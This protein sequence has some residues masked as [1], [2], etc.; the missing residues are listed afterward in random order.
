M[1][2]LTLALAAIPPGE[3]HNYGLYIEARYKGRAVVL[4]R[5]SGEQ[6]DVGRA[7]DMAT[8]TGLL[9]GLL[10]ELRAARA[11]E[12]RAATTDR[13]NSSGRRKTMKPT[14]TPEERD[15]LVTRKRLEDYLRAGDPIQQRDMLVEMWRKYH[16]DAAREISGALKPLMQVQ[17]RQPGDHP[18]LPDEG[19]TND[20]YYV[21]LRRKEDLVF[22]SGPMIQLGIANHD[23]SARHDWRDFQAIK[24]QLAGP[25]CEAFELYPAERRLL[26]PSNYFTLWCFP[27]LGRIKVGQ[28]DRDVRNADV[29]LAPQRAFPKE[30][31]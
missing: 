15:H 28:D 27:K 6:C 31:K 24:N 22:R 21:T 2:P 16:P 9:D 10:A 1:T 13:R 30:E 18:E 12:A 20:T 17:T 4:R 5:C 25:D 8:L 23:G 7:E 3:L 26:D 19:W 14:M 29:A 11:A